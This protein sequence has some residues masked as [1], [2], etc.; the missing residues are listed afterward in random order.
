MYHCTDHDDCVQDALSRADQICAERNLRFTELRRKVLE[1]VWESHGPVK[2]YDILGK[3]DSR[4]AAIKPPTVYRALDFLAENGLVHRLD[5]LNAFVGCS[6]PLKHDECY[7]L[8]C[9]DCGEA[10]ECCNAALRDVISETSRR[11]G[12]EAAHITLEITGECQ[13]CRSAQ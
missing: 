1:I 9:S 7:F 4:I 8:I 10:K 2:A 11:N 12:F 13:D 5:S 6:H 3:L